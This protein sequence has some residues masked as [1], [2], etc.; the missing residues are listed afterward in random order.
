MHVCIILSILLLYLLYY[1]IYSHTAAL[2]ATINNEQ[3]SPTH[4][5]DDYIFMHVNWVDV[6]SFN[7]EPKIKH[8]NSK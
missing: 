6:Q 7:Q 1:N 2:L 8:V 5:I 4:I 3:S